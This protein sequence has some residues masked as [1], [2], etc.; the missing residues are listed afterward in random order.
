MSQQI[1]IKKLQSKLDV[2]PSGLTFGDV[3]EQMKRDLLDTLTDV[4]NR[5]SNHP[6][7]YYI[8]VHAK[9]DPANGKNAIKERIILLDRQPDIKYLGTLLFRIDNKHADAEMIWN[10]PL[11]IPTPGIFHVEPAKRKEVKGAV[12]IADSSKGLPIINRRMN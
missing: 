7:P 1:I 9:L 2:S 4:I 10:L 8:L 11:D 5:K 6:R 12:S 3:R